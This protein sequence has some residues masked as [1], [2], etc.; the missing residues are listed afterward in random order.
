MVRILSSSIVVAAASSTLLMS[1]TDAQRDPPDLSVLGENSW[2]RFRPGWSLTVNDQCLYEFNFQFEHDDTLPMGTPGFQSECTFRNDETKETETADDGK[3]YL[4]PRSF[5]E[6]LPDYVWATIGFN[7]MSIDWHACGHRPKGYALPHYA[8]SFF[9]VTPEFR[10]H[11]MICDL[12]VDDQHVVPGEPVCNFNQDTPEGMGF[13]IVPGALVNRNPVVNMPINFERPKLGNGALPHIGLRS[14]DQDIEPEFPSSW[15]EL[16]LFMSTYQGDSVMWQVH[17]PHKMISG[18][19]D[20]F[21]S[22]TAQ[23]F[24]YTI[25]TLPDTFAFNYDVDDGVVKFTML[26]RSQICRENFERAEAAFGGPPVFPDYG[27]KT[28]NGEEGNQNGDSNGNTDNDQN[29]GGDNGN[30]GNGNDGGGS[31]ALG[32]TSRAWSSLSLAATAGLWI[33]ALW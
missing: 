31:G 19:E 16:V 18:N 11:T 25:P 9:R 4:Q 21:Y 6:R 12:L 8:F 7:H 15:N 26:G 30:N 27:P 29:N 33:A 22:K 1:S 3:E 23:Y 5:W 32:Q 17:V 10:V 14:W 13:W 24:E 28:G 2:Q 20:Q